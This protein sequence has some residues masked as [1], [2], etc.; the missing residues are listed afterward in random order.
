VTSFV[1]SGPPRFCLPVDPEVTN[2]AYA[3]VIVNVDDYGTIPGLAESVSDW[4]AVNPP[5]ATTFNRRFG[6]GPSNTWAFEGR[7][8]GTA[9]A[10]PAVLR[11]FGDRALRILEA[12]RWSKVA[13]TDWR[14][15]TLV[16][17]PAFDQNIARW[18]GITYKDLGTAT[19]HA[20]DGIVVVSTVKVTS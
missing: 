19:R 11:E 3:Q 20:F 5:D 14:N 16:Q 12:H 2:P 17:D 18:T 7:I 6:V 13:R 10:E 8:V 9:D 1:G 4:L 15:Q